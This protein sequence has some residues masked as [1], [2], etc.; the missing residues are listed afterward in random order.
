MVL[1]GDELEL[2]W[3]VLTG[4]VSFQLLS[5]SSM[6]PSLPPFPSDVDRFTPYIPYQVFGRM[7]EG[8][9]DLIGGMNR[10]TLKRW[11]CCKLFG[12]AYCM[13]WDFGI[14]NDFSTLLQITSFRWISHLEGTLSLFHSYMS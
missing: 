11:S 14:Y 4:R 10:F 9:S 1:P 7:V 12:F 6:T 5:A 13:F 2:S 8:T 3:M